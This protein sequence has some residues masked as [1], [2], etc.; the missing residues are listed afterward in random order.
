MK[1]IIQYIQRHIRL[2]GAAIFFLTMETM[3]DLLQ[4][5]FM[6]KI[7]DNGVKNLDIKQIL[8]YGLMMF[9]IAM[10]GAFG[11]VMR[12]FLASHTSQ[13]I[14]KEL[15]SELYQKV[16]GL[17]LENIDRLQPASI[18]TRITNDVTQI[19][20]FINGCMRIMVKAPITCVGAILLVVFQTPQQI[21]VLAVILMISLFL[22]TM[23]MK[24]G[25]P[26]FVRLQQKLDG[27]NTV[28]REFLSS[29]RV[30]KAFQAQRQE[31]EK[32]DEA[33]QELAD[34]GISAMR[35]MAVFSPLINLTV[36]FGIVVLLWLS[37]KETEMEIGRL[38]ASVNYMTQILFALGMI[39]IILNSAIRATASA[40]RIVEVLEETPA[41]RKAEHPEIPD[42]KGEICFQQ[43]FF[44][45]SGSGRNTLHDI[46]FSVK[47][48][49]T[50]GIIGPTGSGK[51]T[52][53]NLIPRFY[54]A[55]RG[56]VQIDGVDVTRMDEEALRTMAAIV[57]QKPLLFS[58]SIRENLLWGNRN[59]SEEEILWAANLACADHFIK[60][61]EQGYDTLL[62]QGGVN[63]SGGQKQ[64]ISLARAL[65][66]KP[67]ILILDDCTSALD[68]KTEAAV[69]EGLR[70]RL[71]G[72]TVMLISQRIATVRKADRILCMENGRI[73]GI[74][75][76]KELM[77]RCETYQEIYR[78]QIGGC[79]ASVIESGGETYVEN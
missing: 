11:A 29:I 18:I 64:R 52:L 22:I 69:L 13:M 17:S 39:S 51:T 66:R 60:Q 71:S 67:K 27:L 45:Y 42:G 3:A 61:T 15:R 31:Q 37:Q 62:G 79:E 16:Q 38:M 72:V 49:E 74:G 65:V 63:L 8:T 1:F 32:F 40:E 53:V 48:G 26:R 76:H 68:A 4:P 12:N 54:D 6:S 43:V 36:N 21:P 35:V 70:T 30:V 24:Q 34:A 44:N 19:Q 33:S 14:G 23:N 50:I 75:T 59:A 73:K 2:F 47:P 56:V 5:T 77:E 46:N 9:G 10:M 57:P 7:V 58:G 25:H 41:Q 55:N 78:S 28:S 20:E